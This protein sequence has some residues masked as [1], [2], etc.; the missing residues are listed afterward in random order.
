MATRLRH[1]PIAPDEDR[2]QTEGDVLRSLVDGLIAEDLF[3]F[4]SR[5][6]IGSVAGALYLP[7]AGDER[8]VQVGLGADPRRLD[9]G[10]RTV[11]FRSR[12]ATTLQPYRLSRPPVLLLGPE[13]AGG[14]IPLTP[15]ELLEVVVD[16]LADDR[17]ANLDEVL[18]GL[19]LAVTQGAVLRGAEWAWGRV[20]SRAVARPT[21]LD[22]EA[23]TALGDRP[24]HP[25]G[26]ARCGW[27]QARYRRYSP[28]ADRPFALDWVA[29][30]RDHLES[31]SVERLAEALSSARVSRRGETARRPASAPPDRDPA[32]ADA[33]LSVDERMALESALSAAGVDGPD[34]VV[35]PVHPWQH[36]HVLSDVFADEWRRGVC[37]PV[38]R[39]LGAFRAT[40]ATRTLM[41]DARELH[42]PSPTEGPVHVKLPLGISTLGAVRLLPPRYLAN[43]A[44]AQRMLEV[45]AGRHPALEGRLHV[46]DE[47]AW[48]AF[49]PPDPGAD[50]YADKPGHLGCLLRVWPDDVGSNLVPLG[51]L[52][53]VNP[54]DGSAPGLARLVADR[55]E[56]PASPAA[57][58]AVFDDVARVVSEVALVSY[59]LGFMPELHGQNA[60]L[61]CEGGRVSGVVLRDHDTV[62]LHRPWLAAAGLPDPA[63]DVKPG[64]PN[65]LW[66]SSPEELLGWFQTLAVEV[67]FQA[68]GRALNSAYGV[69]EDTVWRRLAD[70]VRAARSGVEL[71]PAAAE[72][73]ERQL[74]HAANWPTK[75]V[76]GPLL[77][78]VGTGG[79]SMPSGTGRAGNP[80]L[81]GD[82]RA[83]ELAEHA[84]VERL[85]NCFLRESGVDPVLVGSTVT[86]PFARTG[87]AVVGSLAYRS[88]LG[89]HRFRPGFTLRTGEAVGRA[90][91][92][93][94]VAAE[95][96]A[97]DPGAQDSDASKAFEAFVAD[98]AAK[99]RASLERLPVTG[100][101]D[102]WHAPNPFLAAEQSLR[103]GHPFHP[104]PKASL[105]FTPDDLERYAPELGASF[106][107]HWF[108]VDPERMAEDRL[109]TVRSLD[110]PPALSDAAATQLGGGRATWPLLPCHPWQAAHLTRLPV[111]QDLIAA[112]ALVALG[113]LGSDVFPTASVRTVWDPASGRQLKLPLSVR[114]TNFLRENSREQVR[115]SL[116]ASRALAALGDLDVAVDGPPG[117]FGVLHELGFRRLV[118][119]AGCS[120]RDAEALGA[121]SAVLYRE[122]PAIAGAASPMVVA[123]LLEPDPVDGVPP[124]VRAVQQTGRDAAASRTWLGRYL[125]LS[126]RPLTRLLVRHGIGLEAHTQ[127]SLVVLDDGWPARFV[128][129]DLEGTSLN[130]DN[131]R[132]LG[133]FGAVISADSPSLYGEPEVWQ[134]FSYYV[135]V[136]H[137]GQVVA[138]LAE[139]LGPSEA[140]LWDLAAARLADEAVRH[141]SDPAA[142]PLRHLLDAAE[143]PA[144][145]NLVSVLEG[146]GERP[147]WI[148]IPNPL[149]TPRHS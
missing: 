65:S 17:P 125:E 63:Y 124:L 128:V 20:A 59:G 147:T 72:V 70:V 71:P 37:V 5:A 38:A 114:I 76:L 15:R 87:R 18:E 64:T 58:L 25:T 46:C 66:A 97:Q 84:A 54:E 27:D 113:P 73:T 85:V 43:A 31:G 100:T 88:P 22:W 53:V 130:R 16:G 39:G 106:P 83:A 67:A 19:E 35:L 81:A 80:F 131:P 91:L 109:E 103:I 120:E 94:L 50:R 45:A 90:D 107:L 137:L 146:H 33:L 7:L 51:A 101:V 21:L 11:V 4:R 14:P 132:V 75:L 112:G 99:S 118:A 133:R 122:G 136:N 123:A 1:V 110:P 26:R 74:F 42:R 111:V 96:G 3:G 143:L 61:A 115:R 117:A 23:L 24:F 28:A 9:L 69:A 140:E 12:P 48:W 86:I 60:V 40:A 47:Q 62:R 105:G 41:P 144:K 138:T 57:A 29:V 82:D 68:I 8:H 116:D 44:R 30:R 104:A 10:S 13:G 98:S 142:A 89:H 56:D 102:P 92:V 6:R 79:G 55:G 108:A 93:R 49:C 135:L 32:P 2:R 145:A 134:R 148:G 119:P 77:A 121:A 52:G 126:L 36:A 78:R 129:R 141:G 149:R 139:H 34:H 127:N 95:L